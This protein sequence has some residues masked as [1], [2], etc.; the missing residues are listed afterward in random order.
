MN[1]GKTK[2]KIEEKQREMEELINLGYAYNLEHIHNKREE[3]NNLMHQEEVF[4]RQHLKSN[5]ASDEQQ[6]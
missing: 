6:K 1:F 5:M 4:W 3:L 2:F